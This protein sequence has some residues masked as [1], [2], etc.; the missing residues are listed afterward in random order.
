MNTVLSSR[1][2]HYVARFSIFLIA[3][4]LIAGMVSCGG[5]VEYKLAISS[6]AGGSVTTPG[7]GFFN[8]DEGT[9][10]LLM[11]TPASGY[12]FVEWTGDVDD[13]ADVEDATTA[14]T[15]NADY[16][17]TANFEKEAVTFADPNLEA[18]VREAIAITE[19]PIYPSDLERLTSL[20]AWGKNI[21][22][23]TGLEYCTSLT[24]FYL[25]DNQISDVSP[26]ANLTSLTVLS[27]AYN[28]ISDISPLANLTS[29]TEL[30][31]WDNQISDVSPLAN[32]TSLTYLDLDEN[33]IS[34]ISPLANLTSLIIL[35]LQSNQISDIE[36]L[37]NNP[38]LS[39]EDGVYLGANPLS[40]TSIN[41]Y[42]PQ[43][44]ARGVTVNY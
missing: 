31:L 41:T 33:Q 23:L 17:I 13:I 7:E 22:D 6:T 26:L 5:G 19:G 36:P 25:A 1:R 24:E 37:V 32:L 14:I 16:I 20:D 42:I 30:V 28:D 12:Q 21:A 18:A 40:D 27:L 35:Y 29:L 8:Y 39:E 15:M 43:L 10:V 4:A 34:D 44:E 2:H 3:V 11:A 38:G 9:V